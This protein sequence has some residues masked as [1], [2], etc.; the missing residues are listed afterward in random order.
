MLIFV[1]NNIDTSRSSHCR[2]I[3]RISLILVVVVVVVVVVIFIVVE[4]QQQH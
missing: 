4:Q 3:S 1:V 2:R